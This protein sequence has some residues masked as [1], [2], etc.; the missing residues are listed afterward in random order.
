VPCSSTRSPRTSA[1]TST[2]DELLT[3]R[4]IGAAWLAAEAQSI[5]DAIKQGILQE[6]VN[7]DQEN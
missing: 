4:E 1:T 3:L 7:D 6:V 5:A 2:P